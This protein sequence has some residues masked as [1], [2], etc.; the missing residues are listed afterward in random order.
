MGQ[1]I[2]TNWLEQEPPQAPEII[3]EYEET[4]EVEQSTAVY[5]DCVGCLPMLQ[6]FGISF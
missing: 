3:D 2:S 5:A 6:K 4:A 1:Y